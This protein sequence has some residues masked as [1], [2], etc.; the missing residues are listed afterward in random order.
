MRKADSPQRMVDGAK[1]P[2]YTRKK[3]AIVY[4]QPCRSGLGRALLWHNSG[5]EKT[6]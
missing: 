3:S 5:L 1:A 4:L 6:C 2:Q